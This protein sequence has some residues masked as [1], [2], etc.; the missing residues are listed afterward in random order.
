MSF[1]RVNPGTWGVNSKLTS[2]QI[3][4]LDLDHS[5]AVDKTTAGDTVSG[6]LTFA[7][8]TGAIVMQG[9]SSITAASG[10]TVTIASGAAL[11]ASAGATSTI[12]SGATLA[13]SSAGGAIVTG[14]PQF[15]TSAKIIGPTLT[16]AA[17]ASC[18]PAASR[19][20]LPANFWTVGKQLKIAATGQISSVVTTPGTA[21]FDVRM[22][23]AVVFD[24]QAILLDSVAAHSSVYW[25]LDILLTCTAVGAGVAAQVTGHGK[26]TCEDILGVPATAPKGVL[27]A[28]LPWSSA[29]DVGNF[30]STVTNVFDMF[31]TQTVATGS[32]T[33][34]QISVEAIA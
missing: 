13:V 10:A 17:S 31:F 20:V 22:G 24:G 6:T 33:L 14:V 18:I 28:V 32:L 8:G 26:W 4:Q 34:R 25:W 30:D 27:T 9:T 2:T 15:I 1:P 21:R 7:T 5:N 12:A 16:A 3:N 11:T 23:S 19:V 29:S